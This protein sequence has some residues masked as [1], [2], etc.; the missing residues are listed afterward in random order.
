[1][2]KDYVNIKQEDVDWAKIEPRT[3]EKKLNIS[4]N[5]EVEN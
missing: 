1:M 4:D 2:S 5:L 3:E